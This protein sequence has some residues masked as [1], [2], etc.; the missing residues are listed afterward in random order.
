M[1]RYIR[2]ALLALLVSVVS[3]AHPV[4]AQSLTFSLFERYVDS[5]RQQSGIPGLSGAIVQDGRIVWERGFGMSD[6]ERSVAARPDTPYD[7]SGLTATFSAAVLLEQCVET[8]HATLEDRLQSWVPF[9]SNPDPTLRDVL[10][11]RSSSGGFKYDADRYAMLTGAI[12]ACT[13]GVPT[14]FRLTV[15]QKIF[16]RLGMADSV[17]GQTVDGSSPSDHGYFTDGQLD[18]FG[19]VLQRLA[20]PYRATGGTQTLNTS[21]PKVMNAATGAVS[22]VRDLARYDG[23]LNDVV[24][25]HRETMSDMWSSARTTSGAVMPTGLGW[26]VQNYNG[27]VVYWQ[28]GLT[29]GAYSSL[30]LKLPGKHV[31]LILLANSDGL[32]APFGLQ[33]GDVTASLFA[34]AFLRLFVG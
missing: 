26:F 32:S 28:F 19:R 9:F 33:E 5:L 18:R 16:D 21:P 30:M 17:P 25:L 10:T 29:Q 20:L 6:V 22:T 13:R 3:G 24:L 2:T 23:A 34:R 15:A 31:T 14:P 7:I 12:E 11:H 8:G 4:G 1:A 27:Q